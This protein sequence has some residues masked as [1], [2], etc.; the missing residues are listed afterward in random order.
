MIGPGVQGRTL[1]GPRVL[2]H[3]TTSEDQVVGHFRTAC[4]AT[5]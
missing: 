5:R 3:V 2:G 4:C 1:I